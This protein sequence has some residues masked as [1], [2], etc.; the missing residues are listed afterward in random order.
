MELVPNDRFSDAREMLNALNSLTTG[1]D[2]PAIEMSAFEPYRTALL[3][4]IIYP[5]E[6]NIGQAQSHIYRSTFNGGRVIVKIWYG[7]TPDPSRTRECSQLLAFLDKARIL[8]TQSSDLY[9]ELVDFGDRCGHILGPKGDSW[10]FADKRHECRARHTRSSSTVPSNSL[11]SGPFAQNG[12]R[13]RGPL[14]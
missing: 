9:P 12:I 1:I 7:T 6:E 14:P 11:C 13:A 8:K 10:D 4:L 2:R 3:P 5:I